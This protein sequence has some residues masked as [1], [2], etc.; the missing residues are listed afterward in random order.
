MNCLNPFFFQAE[1]APKKLPTSAFQTTMKVFCFS[2]QT[3]PPPQ[4]ANDPLR[5][6]ER[7]PDFVGPA[8]LGPSAFP[9]VLEATRKEP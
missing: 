5:P 2:V 7:Q 6:A 3:L 4:S 1:N 9:V 8:V